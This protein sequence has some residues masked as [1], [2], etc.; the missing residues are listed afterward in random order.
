MDEDFLPYLMSLQLCADERALGV[1]CC[2][3]SSKPS[4][5]GGSRGFGRTSA[6][7]AEHIEQVRELEDFD[8][9]KRLPQ[10]YLEEWCDEDHRYMTKT[11]DEDKEEYVFV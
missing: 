4:R 1:F 8:A 3:F 7:L 2:R 11:Y 10:D 9:P 6:T 5:A